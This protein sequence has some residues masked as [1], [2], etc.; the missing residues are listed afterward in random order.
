MFTWKCSLNA[1]LKSLALTTFGLYLGIATCN[2]QLPSELAAQVGDAAA[3]VLSA[4]GVPSASIAIV[5]DGKIAYLN[6]YGRARIEPQL[7]ATPAMQYSV[8]S[9][10]KQFTAAA[11]MFLVEQGKLSLDDPIAKFIPDL[12]RANEVT[13]RMVLSHTSG[14]Q[15][16]WPEDY[17]MTSMMEP[18]TSQRILDVWGR[19]PLDFE[20]GTKWQ[21]SNTNYVIAGRIVEQLSGDTL[22]HFL[23][24]HIFTPLGMTSVL[25]TDAARLPEGDPIGYQRYALGPSRPA[26][27]EGAGWMFAAG[28]LAMSPRDLALWNIS[29]INQSLLKPSSYA[30]M[31]KPVVL[32]DGKNSGYGL[33]FFIRESDDGL[34]YEHS[35]EVSGF[36][37]ENFVD[38]GRK[39]AVTV[40]TNEMASPA[41]GMLTRAIALKLSNTEA[42]HTPEETK[43]LGILTGLQ[44]GH[45]DRS[46]LTSYCSAYFSPQAVSD[47]ASSLGPLGKP[48]GIDTEKE[49]LRGGMTFRTFS[50]QF[51]SPAAHPARIGITTYVMPDGKLEQFLVEPAA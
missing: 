14:Y 8:G 13:V 36:V 28:E 15:D 11:I 5:K 47:F 48:V 46:L 43:A 38:P 26:P 30:E 34:A 37:S 18:T 51:S 22:M 7:D 12:T 44:A 49:E 6:A 10:S 42:T 41:A 20:P 21:Y 23:Q 24:T 40:L 19:K 9:I 33:G 4:T 39:F 1:V 16:Y 27:K 29:I 35:G 32:K 25:N 31:F 2:A 45:L 3:Q 50:V 17:V